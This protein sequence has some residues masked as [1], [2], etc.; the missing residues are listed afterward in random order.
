MGDVMAGVVLAYRT[1]AAALK[2]AA[3]DI[4]LRRGAYSDLQSAIEQ[5]PELTDAMLDELFAAKAR[6]ANPRL[7]PVQREILKIPGL[8]GL[9]GM[10]NAEIRKVV[11]RTEGSVHLAL[12]ALERRGLVTSVGGRPRRWQ[13]VEKVG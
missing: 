11:G 5:L 6:R 2:K 4:E 13:L 9:P 1:L 7:G 3:D 8:K 10:S 12:H